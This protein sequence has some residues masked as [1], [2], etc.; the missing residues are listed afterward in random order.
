MLL[1]C[2]IPISDSNHCFPL[3]QVFPICPGY[4]NPMQSQFQPPAIAQIFKPFSP[5]FQGNPLAFKYV[6]Y[7]LYVLIR[8]L[9]YISPFRTA[10]PRFCLS[11][12]LPQPS[13]SLSPNHLL[14]SFLSRPIPSISVS[15]RA[16]CLSL[17]ASPASLL[18]LYIPPRTNHL[19]LIPPT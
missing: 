11:I 3:Y 16:F 13:P 9:G 2:S 4:L 15:Q 7:Y 10:F 6:L 8:I 17:T 18:P 1:Y 19:L 14:H 12:S 5:V